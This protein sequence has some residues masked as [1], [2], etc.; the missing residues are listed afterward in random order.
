MLTF[1]N[2]IPK[3]KRIELTQEQR[4][5]WFNKVKNSSN[6]KN[7]IKKTIV[8]DDESQINQV[9]DSIT[10]FVGGMT[11]FEIVKTTPKF[12]V[13]FINRGYYN[14]IGA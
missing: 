2:E 14:N 9:I 3:A 5:E 13:R 10:Y 6:W 11:D 12:S 8:L 7:P 1:V 4:Q